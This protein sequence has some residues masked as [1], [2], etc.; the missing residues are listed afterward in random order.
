MNQ[1]QQGLRSVDFSRARDKVPLTWFF[2][3]VMSAKPRPAAGSIRYSVCPAPS[4]GAA[5][6]HSVK[7]SVRGDRWSCFACK[8][9]GDVV[10]AAASWWGKP[11]KDAALDLVGAD[12]EIINAYVPPKP[13]PAVE[14]DQPMVKALIEKLWD[15]TKTPTQPVIN[16]LRSRGIPESLTREAAR[17]GM[18]GSL[19]DTPE[20]CKRKLVDVLG[21]DAM[22]EAGFW[23]EGAKAPAAAFRPLLM[24]SY[25]RTD[26]EMRLIRSPREGER[27]AL[28]FGDVSPWV[29]VGADMDR[30]ML[31]EGGIDL[32]S[33]VAM[34]TRRSII[35]LPGCENWEP[36]WFKKLAGKDVMTAFDANAAGRAATERITPVLKEIGANTSAYQN[37]PGYEDLNDELTQKRS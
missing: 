34:G 22:Y 18:I 7:V 28:H 31:T 6:K 17:R 19:P 35:G 30:I 23:R 1:P 10:E 11:L 29:W 16:Y 33:A 25:A 13:L 26:L 12:A 14:R 32:L 27:K 20:E 36:E 4:C 21:M 2:E 3:N 8:E 37:K 9:S 5:S 24:I 15:A